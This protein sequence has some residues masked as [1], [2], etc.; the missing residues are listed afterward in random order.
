MQMQIKS[1]LPRV[2]CVI[3]YLFAI[4]I[5]IW[6][7]YQ[8]YMKTTILDAN[9]DIYMDKTCINNTCESNNNT[10][11]GKQ[12]NALY[13]LYIIFIVLAILCLVLSFTKYTKI[14]NIVG[15]LLLGMALAV[16]ITLI[17]IVKTS[18]INVAVNFNYNFTIASILVIVV[19]CLMIVKQSVCNSMLHS[20]GRAIMRMK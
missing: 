11:F 18:Y 2:L 17:I 14:C 12:G 1:L 9:M 10:N 6:A 20:A 15:L 19:C 4:S 7:L 3:T 5:T 8:P 16:M 13:A